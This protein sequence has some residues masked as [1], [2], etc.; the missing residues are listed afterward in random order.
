MLGNESVI[1]QLRR[2]AADGSLSHAILITGEKGM[3]KKELAHLI[4]LEVF[5]RAKEGQKACLVC[6]ECKKVLSDNHPDM[7][8]VTHEKPQVVSVD[9]IRTQVSDQAVI[10]PYEGGRKII[11]IDDAAKMNVQAQNA[12]LKTLEEPP[13]YVMILLLCENEHALLDTIRSRC[14]P[15]KLEKVDRQIIQQYLIDE[16]G[17]D[18][19]KAET[20][21]AFAAGNPGRAIALSLSDDF[22]KI[23]LMVVELC[24]NIRKMNAAQIAQKAKELCAEDPALALELIEDW[25]RDVLI[26]RTSGEAAE[27]VFSGEKSAIRK[28][29]ELIDARKAS[30]LLEMIRL[31]QRR[32]DANVNKELSMALLLH[33]MREI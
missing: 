11:V 10:R 20:A 1:K 13:E 31:T 29:M 2:Q 18:R 30:E 19:E 4:G 17:V 8:W 12:L 3:G 27:P 23:Y 22:Q 24:K 15:V 9:D 28:Q 21:A 14:T 6:P 33:K 7:L 32:L 26:S 5:C 25:I 16:H